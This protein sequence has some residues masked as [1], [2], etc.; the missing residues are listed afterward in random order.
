MWSTDRFVAT[1]G[2]F[3]QRPDAVN[4]AQ[5]TTIKDMYAVATGATA[6]KKK[7]NEDSKKIKKKK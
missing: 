5:Y 1:W 6:K 7:G 3:L 2:E 4:D